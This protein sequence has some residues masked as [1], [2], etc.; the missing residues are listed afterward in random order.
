MKKLTLIISI[1]FF[2]VSCKMIPKQVF[3]DSTEELKKS[4]ITR[5]VQ[6]Q[7]DGFRTSRDPGFF[8]WWYF[9]AH[10]DDGST[11]VIV[12]MARSIMVY[13]ES[14]QPTVMITLTKPNQEKIQKTAL[15]TPK[16]FSASKKKCDVKI[17]SNWVTGNL[18]NYTLHVDIEN[19][20]ANLKFSGIIPP[21]RPGGGKKYFADKEHYFGW[22]VPIPN[23][24]VKGTLV[25][26]GKAKKIRGT[27]YHDHNWGNVYLPSVIDHWYWGRTN[28]DDYTILFAVETTRETYGSKK[29]PSLLL[30]KGSK[31]LTGNGSL[32]KLKTSK[33]TSD[34]SGRKYPTELDF[35]WNLNREKIK[36]TLRNPDVIESKGLL[37]A[38]PKW[39]QKIARKFSNPYYLRFNS[40][41]DLDIDFTHIK[42]HKKGKMLYELMR[43]K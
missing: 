43:F 40:N 2:V 3:S 41:I 11:L 38:L 35:T 4:G 9:D 24:T 27:G 42:D 23:G 15:V 19:V 16:I 28:I 32:L 20:S 5:T 34:A 12:Y 25:V 8:E 21:W 14:L 39:K 17:G 7:E 10:L 31:I 26:D 30:A 33:F 13:K 1:L 22:V 37:D 6:I 29:L 18:H 36:F